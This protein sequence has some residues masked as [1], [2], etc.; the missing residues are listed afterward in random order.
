[1]VREDLILGIET[2]CDDTGVSII[3]TSISRDNPEEINLDVLSNKLA[4]QTELHEKYGGVVPELASRE[5][6]RS[7]LPL[8]K[9]AL[10]ESDLD[11]ACLSK[12]AVTTGPGLKGSL[13]TGLNFAAGLA[14]ALKKPLI[15][16]NHLEGHVLSAFIES[17]SRPQCN[18]PF[19]TLLIS[20]GHTQIILAKR[21]GEYE[22]LGETV[23][24]S[25]GE[26]FDKVSKELGYGYPG[27]PIIEE[28]AKKGDPTKYLFPK[29][30]LKKQGL[31]FS[32]SGLKTAVIREIIKCKS[33]KER[34]W[35]NN[36]A[37]SLQNTVSILL[38]SKIRNAITL[39]GTDSLVVSGGVAANQHIRESLSNLCQAMQ[40]N[41]RVPPKDLCTDNGLMIA[42]AACLKS[43]LQE[44]YHIE[45]LKVRPRWNI[46]TRG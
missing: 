36:I 7:L 46:T 6:L 45:E 21:I 10:F 9:Q 19:L 35:K 27:G 31:N 20:G 39:T 25:I 26:T 43:I 28:L 44:N 5:H 30:L 18:F 17:K 42:W 32:F 8:T 29:P 4:S 3:K 37:A 38:A 15:P 16:I 12:I 2:S 14:S 23:D 1:M 33:S 41:L 40:V 34:D 11:L 22:L 13:L 24:D